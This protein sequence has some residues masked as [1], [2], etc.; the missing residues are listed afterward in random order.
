MTTGV[1]L[2]DDPACPVSPEIARAAIGQLFNA[3]A[4]EDSAGS[5]GEAVDYVDSS[6]NGSVVSGQINGRNCT[7]ASAGGTTVRLCD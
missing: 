3:A 2:R 7:Y 5:G 4:S 1:C 6:Q